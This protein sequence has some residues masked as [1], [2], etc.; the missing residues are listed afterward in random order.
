MGKNDKHVAV[1]NVNVII[2]C[3]LSKKNVAICNVNGIKSVFF[4]K[5]SVAVF[6][7]NVIIK[8]VWLKENVDLCNDCND[9][10]LYLY[11]PHCLSAYFFSIMISRRSLTTP[12]IWYSLIPRSLAYIVRVSLPVIWSI[13]ASNWGQYPRFCCTCQSQNQLLSLIFIYKTWI[14]SIRWPISILSHI[15][16]QM[17]Y[18]C[19]YDF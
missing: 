4:F 2:K 19:I 10:I 16:C 14:P 17:T 9:N 8:C 3:V 15:F 13:N 6:N 1:C 12:S 18:V 5:E 11:V 7:V